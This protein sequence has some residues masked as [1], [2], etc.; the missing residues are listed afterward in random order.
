MK[1][2][3]PKEVFANELRTGIA[4]VE[5]RSVAADAGGIRDLFAAVCLCFAVHPTPDGLVLRTTRLSDSGTLRPGGERDTENPHS[6]ARRNE[7]G[8][9]PHDAP[10]ICSDVTFTRI[11]APSRTM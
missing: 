8:Q 2:G 10:I 7:T 1:V 11:S 3:V 4:S 9:L 5:L 6:G